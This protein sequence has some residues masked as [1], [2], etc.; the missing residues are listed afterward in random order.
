MPELMRS[1]PIET[2][3]GVGNLTLLRPLVEF[4]REGEL[5]VR[6]VRSAWRREKVGA[7]FSPFCPNGLLLGLDGPNDLFFNQGKHLFSVCFALVEAQIPLV[8]V[9]ADEA[10]KGKLAEL[11]DAQ[12]Q[13]K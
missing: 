4:S 12:A 1:K 5:L 10:I 11:I 7:G 3:I 2:L 9:I 8:F 13:F 6:G